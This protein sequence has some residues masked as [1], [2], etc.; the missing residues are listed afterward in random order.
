MT[1]R[2]EGLLVSS[3]T[4]RSMPT[5]SPRGRR[6]AVFERADVVLVH[7]VGFEVAGGPAG[8]LGLE[9]APLL[10]RIVELAERVGDFE[11]ADVELEALDGLGVVRLLLRERRHFGRKVVDEGRLD[12]IVLVQPLEDLGRDP[13]GAPPGVQLESQPREP[14]RPPSRDREGRR[15][16]RARPAAPT[17][18]A[19]A[20]SRSDTRRYGAA[21][22]ISCSP[23][24]I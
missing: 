14:G 7:H 24:L 20:P 1:S 3:M 22:E 18:P 16:S 13:P 10:G 17:R 12:E 5:P 11:A 4:S 23:N 6:Q 2:I 15:R 21:S 19:R 8:D 9:P